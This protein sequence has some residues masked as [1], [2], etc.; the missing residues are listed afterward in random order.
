[1]MH[2]ILEPGAM[3]G[4]LGG[5]QLGAMFTGA[6]RRMGYRVAIWDPDPDAPA[7]RVA[8]ES[9][10]ASFADHD[11]R[12]RFIDTVQAITLEWENIPV[13]LCQWLEQHRTLRPSSAVLRIIQDRLTQK[14][15]LSS[16]SLPVPDFA[17][18][19]SEHQLHQVISRL[20]LPLICKTARSG[21]D[22]KGQWLIRQPSEIAQFEQILSTPS[23]GVRW[24]AEQVVTFVR[25][26]SVLVVRSGTSRSK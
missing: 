6:A 3:L 17:E 20:G 1:M 7:H 25:E 22:G 9:F 23:S 12:E 2:P 21:Y 13:E 10:S 15:F 14:Q 24:I 19:T 4:V 16:C 26:L 5:G 11:T 18:V 8:D